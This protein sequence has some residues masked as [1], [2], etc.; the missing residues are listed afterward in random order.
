M[1]REKDAI[2]IIGDFAF[3]LLTAVIGLLMVAIVCF[4]LWS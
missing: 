4:F 1:K 2:E 3:W